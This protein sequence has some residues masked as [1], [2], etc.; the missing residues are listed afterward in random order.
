MSRS[1]RRGFTLIELLV[2]IAI[3]AVLIGLLRP[4]V[5]A[6]REAARRAQCMNNLKQLGLAY[7]NY[8]DGNNVFPP[9]ELAVPG[10][11]GL[12]YMWSGFVLPFIE[13][14]TLAN[15]YNFQQGMGAGTAAVQNTTVLNTRIAAYQC[16]SDNPGV[17]SGGNPRSNY[18]A[19]YSPDGSMVE[20]GVPYTY[21]GGVRSAF[22]GTR[23]AMSNINVAR[24]VRDATD[25][26]SS[27]VILSEC[28]AGASGSPDFRGMWYNDFGCQYTHHKTPNSLLPDTF[29]SAAW[30]PPICS[31]AVKPKI[32][33]N[34]AGPSWDSQDYAARSYHPGG[35]Q[36]AMADGSVKFFKDTINLG[37]WQAVASINAGEV[38]SADQY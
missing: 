34:G 27:T 38:L 17:N 15:A 11:T 23:K 35:V 10:L 12:R 22:P 33:C 29:W 21:G 28:I 6:S 24:G 2:V 19:T 20:P 5:Q 32:P 26:T 13:Q 1:S 36:T 4:A 3:I 7:H 18:V 14:G 37:I 30:L 25:G 9:G 31:M 8:H 16:P